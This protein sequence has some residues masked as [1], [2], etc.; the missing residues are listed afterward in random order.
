MNRYLLSVLFFAASFLCLILSIKVA[1]TVEDISY[2]WEAESAEEII[3]PFEIKVDPQTSGGRFVQVSS[4]EGKLI[5]NLWIERTG[6]YTLWGRCKWTNGCSDSVLVII[7]EEHKSILGNDA[8]YDVWHWVEGSSC[9]FHKGYNE[10]I[11]EDVERT[12]QVDS[13][14]LTTSKKENIQQIDK[15]AIKINERIEFNDDFYGWEGWKANWTAISEKWEIKDEHNLQYVEQISVEPSILFSGESFWR[16]YSVQAAVRVGDK[17]ALGLLFYYQDIDN[18]YL[19]R[20]VVLGDSTVL[21]VVR[22]VNGVDHILG[23]EEIPCKPNQWYL[24]RVEILGNDIQVLKNNKR[25]LRVYDSHFNSGMVGL[26]TSKM[27]EGNFDDVKVQSID[28]F[29]ESTFAGHGEKLLEVVS[30]EFGNEE[31]LEQWRIVRG[32]WRIEEGSLKCLENKESIESLIFHNRVIYGEFTVKAKANFSPAGDFSLLIGNP[33]DGFDRFYRFKIKQADKAIIIR[34]MKNNELIKHNVIEIEGKQCL[35]DLKRNKTK[36]SLYI[37]NLPALEMNI[38]KLKANKA[39]QV[40]FALDQGT[41]GLS[42]FKISEVPYYY[43]SAWDAPVGWQARQGSIKIGHV[44][45]YAVNLGD[46]AIVWNENNFDTENVTFE[47]PLNIRGNLRQESYLEIIVGNEGY[48]SINGYGLKIEMLEQDSYQS[49][50]DSINAQITLSRERVDI[51]SVPLLLQNS[52]LISLKKEKSFIAVYLNK[53][54][55]LR[56]NDPNPL[57][58]QRLGLIF[59]PIESRL[60]NISTIIA[61]RDLR[62]FQFHPSF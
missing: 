32:D 53:K 20:I 39:I 60:I 21:Q 14:L 17:G 25:I 12:V 23:E 41:L 35:I 54:E 38:E 13:F 49:T 48:F 40:G 15:A 61:I 55:I 62:V 43:Y 27:R 37:N 56:Y 6:E 31:E 2:F 34:L 42:S 5:H 45:F 22:V 1:G 26:F 46:E 58:G 57:K 52:Q 47:I 24:L 9:L 16:D 4:G 33:D 28:K 51:V 8:N 29:S 59:S 3:T 50:K 19:A 11:I 10:I 30:H 18:H 7:N 36:Y 44:Y